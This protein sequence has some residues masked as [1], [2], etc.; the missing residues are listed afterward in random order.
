MQLQSLTTMQF[1]NLTIT[2]D[3]VIVHTLRFVYF[4]NI[5]TLVHVGAFRHPA[6]DGGGCVVSNR[7]INIIVK[8]TCG[9]YWG[10]S[11]DSESL[12]NLAINY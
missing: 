8:C 1:S 5:N 2:I 3:L 4:A 12:T 9:G 6:I 7:V 11:Y 10:R